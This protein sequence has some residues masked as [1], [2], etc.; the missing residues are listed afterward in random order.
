MLLSTIDCAEKFLVQVGG[1]SWRGDIN[2]LQ[3]RLDSLQALGMFLDQ[4]HEV[5]QWFVRGWLEDE[6]NRLQL[7]RCRF[8]I[9]QLLL[10]FFQE[11]LQVQ[12]KVY[13]PVKRD[14]RE[15]EREILLHGAARDRGHS[16]AGDF[17][18]CCHSHEYRATGYTRGVCIYIYQIHTHTS[19]TY[20]QTHTCIHTNI[21]IHLVEV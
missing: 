18:H 13:S 1:A 7:V 11:T 3:A 16:A 8:Q 17:A 2:L 14:R 10:N 12:T 6:T 4:L 19:N 20:T 5:V 21:H 15:R 9:Y